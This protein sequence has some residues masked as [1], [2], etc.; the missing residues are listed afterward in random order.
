M[1]DSLHLSNFGSLKIQENKFLQ[2][3]FR[4]CFDSEALLIIWKKKNIGRLICGFLQLSSPF[5]LGEVCDA[6]K[7]DIQKPRHVGDLPKG[8]VIMKKDF[9]QA[10]TR[11]H[12]FPGQWVLQVSGTF[13]PAS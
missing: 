2:N 1:E 11:S 7:T 13:L 4:D 8:N 3:I 10:E 6:V 12:F 5:S 9:F